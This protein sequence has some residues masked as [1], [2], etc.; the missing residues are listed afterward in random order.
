MKKRVSNTVCSGVGWLWLAGSFLSLQAQPLPDT[1]LKRCGHVEYE[2]VLRQR[3]PFRRTNIDAL[4]QKILAFKTQ[5]AQGRTTETIYRIPVVVHVIH[6]NT[7]GFIGGDNNPNI[8]DE[9][10]ASQIRVL[11]EDYRRQEG[12][13]GFNTDPV[14]ADMG[15]EFFLAQTDPNG[16]STTGITRHYNAKESFDVFRDDVLLSQIAYWPSDRYLNIWVAPLANNYLG[17]AQFPEG[18]TT[19]PG[20]S[21]GETNEFTDG[22]IIDYRYFGRSIGTVRNSTY[23]CGRTTT[24]EIGH[25]LGLIHTWGD[26]VC[27]DDYVADTPPTERANQTTQC[28][29][30]FSNCNNVRT[31]NQIENYMDY[32][33]DRCMNLFTQGQRNRVRAVLTLSPRRQRLLRSLESL[34]QTET[35]TLQL[36]PNPADAEA[37][38]DVLFT[39]FKTFTLRVLD[40]NGRLIRS[41]QYTDVPSTRVFLP[42]FGLPTGMYVVQ[43]TTDSEKISSRLLVR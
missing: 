22:V 37:I 28:T 5:Q 15:I 24:H 18:G 25:W 7:S 13:P 2:Q 11:N 39:G 10:I 8:S 16:R 38:A 17:I 36:S 31:R 23:C 12:T 34:P 41:V 6:Y 33:P 1:A 26:S 27:G 4:N 21:V 19:I 29:Q 32:S 30:T 3:D 43:V 40:L 9:Q 35:L 42:V 20:L 14:G